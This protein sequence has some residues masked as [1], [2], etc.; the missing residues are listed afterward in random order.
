MKK[1][2]QYVLL[3]AITGFIA[4]PVLA[5]EKVAEEPGISGFFMLGAGALSVESN[6]LATAV[7]GNVDL[8]DDTIGDLDDDADSE[9]GVIPLVNLSLTYTFENRAT[10][11]FFGNSLEDF[12]RFDFSTTLGVRHQTENLGIFEVASLSTPIATEVWED[13]Y[14]TDASREETDRTSDGFR[15]HWGSI[16]DSHFDLRVS[17]REIDIDKE[18]SGDSLVAA[19]DITASEQELL[20][21]NGDVNVASI[22]YNRR[23]DEGRFLIVTGNSIDYDLD[24]DAMSQDGFTMQLTYGTRL[25]SRKRL[26][27][28]FELGSFDFDKR[29][30]VFDEKN[31]RDVASLTMTLFLEDPF[32]FKDWI[33]NTGFVYGQSDH[34]IDFY[35]TQV[36]MINF[37]MLRRF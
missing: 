14:L 36:A 23:I 18:R 25:D 34:D 2:G 12:L 5:V 37:G 1:F 11:L 16:L 27:T 21:R 31:S 4:S 24:G 22:I 35:D 10:E 29:N 15:L 32:G 6:T 26:V 19:G 20:D 28:N 9:S 13:P 33:S 17:S 3:A 8:G 7:D 30:P